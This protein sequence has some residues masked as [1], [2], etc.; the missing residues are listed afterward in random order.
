VDS[1]K[2]L[3]KLGDEEVEEIKDAIQNFDD[4]A[5]E[6]MLN[7]EKDYY[8]GEDR[9]VVGRDVEIV[10]EEDINRMKKIRSYKGIRHERGQKVRGQRTRST[11]RTGGTVGVKVSEVRAEEEE[12]GEE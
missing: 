6:W 12:G 3:G 10:R 4:V 7:R 1:K 11:G 9:H 8:T 5:P 2:L